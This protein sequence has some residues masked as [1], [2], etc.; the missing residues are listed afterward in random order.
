MIKG[1]DKIKVE[2]IIRKD[3]IISRQ[4]IA[5]K[6]CVALGFK[7][8]GMFLIIDGAEDA[9][10]KAKELL[11]DIASEY[12]EKESV[13]KKYDEEQDQAAEGFGFILG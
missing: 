2:N 13:L 9:I 3:D 10:K 7:E 11:K 8:D 12:K 4:S 5:I 1:E 6:S